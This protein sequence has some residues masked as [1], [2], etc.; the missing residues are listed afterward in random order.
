[1]RNVSPRALRV[2]SSQGTAPFDLQASGNL[3]LNYPGSTESTENG[4][5]YYPLYP[6]TTPSAD[7]D[8]PRIDPFRIP[9]RQPM[10]AQ[11][12]PNDPPRDVI[13]CAGN[14]Y[15]TESSNLTPA[16]VGERIVEPVLIDYKGKKCFFFVF[17]VRSFI[18]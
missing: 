6:F 8:T 12:N 7:G 3:R 9:R 1:M 14:H 16:L 13:L 11:V 2:S 10:L 5:T 15:V 17:G 4:Y 18:L